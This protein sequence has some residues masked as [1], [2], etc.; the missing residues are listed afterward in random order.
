MTTVERMRNERNVLAQ[1]FG[2]Y[3]DYVKGYTHALRIIEDASKEI[4]ELSRKLRDCRNELC[5][6]CGDYK[7]AHKGA[8]DGCRWKGEG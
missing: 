2:E 8:C 4:Q 5:L 1:A 7:M 6:K 3:D